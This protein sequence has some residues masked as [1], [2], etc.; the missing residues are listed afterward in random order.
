M[1]QTYVKRSLDILFTLLILLPAL[2]VA[3]VV[4]LVIKL[5]D[6]GPIFFKHERYGRHKVPFT[7]YK[8][9]TMVVS[10]PRNSP[11]N[12]LINANSYI[13]RPG[14]IIRKL[15]LDELPQLINVL[16]GDMTIVGP[17]PVILK[18]KDLIAERA[19][20][21]ANSCKPGITGWAQVNGRDEVRL[22]EKAKLDG[23]YARNISF[24]MDLKCVLMTIW[25]VVLIKGHKEGAIYND[26][27][28]NGDSQYSNAS[29]ES[30]SM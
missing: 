11:T 6:R 24:L 7:I 25:A 17:R 27:M 15:S 16:K 28:Q 19:R 23:E 20:Y 29:V 18:E 10:A 21:K 14:R 12:S 9:R 2:P 4:A 5:N 8:F 1:Y 26:L 3:L 13:T 22:K 30:E